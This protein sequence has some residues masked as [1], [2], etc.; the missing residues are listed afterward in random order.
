LCKDRTNNQ[1]IHCFRGVVLL[2][3]FSVVLSRL[4][5]KF[6]CNLLS[7][8]DLESAQLENLGLEVNERV[9]DRKVDVDKFEYCQPVQ[10]RVL[11]LL[12]VLEI[13]LFDEELG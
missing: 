13:L 1:A 11:V 4:I 8:A 6:S 7:L 3:E 5:A 10:K 9:D 2:E 12:K